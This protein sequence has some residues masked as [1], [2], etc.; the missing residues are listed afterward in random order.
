[1]SK[2]IDYC[3]P[4]APQS[5]TPHRHN[6]TNIILSEISNLKSEQKKIYKLLREINKKLDNIEDKVDNNSCNIDNNYETIPT[7]GYSKWEM[8]AP[9]KNSGMVDVSSILASAQIK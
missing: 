9:K 1:M 8:E 5:T 3:S 2:D 4:N 6:P 7:S